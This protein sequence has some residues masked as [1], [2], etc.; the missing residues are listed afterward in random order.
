MSKGVDKLL[1]MWYNNVANGKVFKK[2]LD[3]E[4]TGRV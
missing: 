2:S 4:G 1:G 3:K